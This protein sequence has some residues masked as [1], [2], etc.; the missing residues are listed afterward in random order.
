MEST[1]TKTFGPSRSAAFGFSG[2]QN[3]SEWLKSNR[4][5]TS[6]HVDV[7]ERF[8][9]VSDEALASA[10]LTPEQIALVRRAEAERE[11]LAAYLRARNA[12]YD[13]VSAAVV[14]EDVASA[15][16]AENAVVGAAEGSENGCGDAGFAEKCLEN[17]GE[18]EFGSEGEFVGFAGDGEAFDDAVCAAFEGGSPTVEGAAVV[19][20]SAPDRSVEAILGR[21]RRVYRY[22]LGR[23]FGRAR[24]C[25]FALGSGLLMPL[26]GAVTIRERCSCDFDPHTSHSGRGPPRC[27]RQ[28]HSSHPLGAGS[29]YDRG[30]G[31]QGMSRHS[32]GVDGETCTVTVHMYTGRVLGKSDIY[33]YAYMFK[34]ICLC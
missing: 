18:N 15:D 17:E 30:A 12:E 32:I 23:G 22:A 11:R 21:T 24:T 34:H 1:A 27:R 2:P 20:S 8:E 7:P 25:P 29:R 19:V 3:G 16:G 5:V 33:V 10:G 28:A 6:G 14:T 13:A 9:T 26:E 4:D 31:A